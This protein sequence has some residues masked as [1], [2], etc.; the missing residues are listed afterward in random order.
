[1]SQNFW[2]FFAAALVLA[3]LPGPSIFYVS[4]RSLA[5]GKLEGLASGAGTGIGGMVHVVAGTLG[6]SALVLAS[7]KLFA[8]LK[9][10]GA[11][12]LVWMGIG[13]IRSA[14]RDAAMLQA[15]EPR[16]AN[17]RRAVI[18][19]MLVEA[20]NPKTA[21]FFLAFLPQFVDLP[22]G[23][24]ALQFLLLGLVSVALNTSADLA[25]ALAAGAVRGSL[26]GRGGVIARVRQGAGG[27]MIGLGVDL[28]LTRRL[29]A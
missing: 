5:A 22:R 28:L 15:V 20:L 19:G 6:L 27:L 7:A 13:M 11:V 18:D 4:S 29:A 2:M 1:M 3:L 25:V 17:P 10:A 26:A 23:H 8:L 9:L 16:P 21:T 14:R 24:V 12:Y